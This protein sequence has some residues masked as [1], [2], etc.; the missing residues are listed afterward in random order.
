MDSLRKIFFQKPKHYVIAV[1]L[2]AVVAV[3]RT[4][5]LPQGLEMWF[6]LNEVL[7]VAGSVTFLI[8]ALLAV[9]Y[10]GA[11]DLFGYVFSP[12]RTGEHRKYKNYAEYA[13]VKEE[14][15]SR[16]GYHFVPYFT[17]GILVFLISFF[18]A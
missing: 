1:I 14:K 5:A 13:H 2:T 7:S 10:Y 12:G 8:G 3:L 4:I 17:V 16:S 9:A 18:F 11:F 6:V 15:R